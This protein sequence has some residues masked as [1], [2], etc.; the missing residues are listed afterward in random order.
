MKLTIPLTG[1]VLAEG[2]VHGAGDL[3]GDEND[4]IRPIDIDL[5]NVSWIM[6]DVDLENEVMIIEVEPEDTI[7]EP[8]GETDLGTGEPIYRRR[9]TSEQ[10][11]AAFLQH[12]QKLIETHTKGE[13]YQMS[14]CS[15]LNRPL[16]KRV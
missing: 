1:T 2:S 16:R 11:K 14:G 7:G 5:G 3:M 12:A 8:T 15:R 6:V 9:I 10:E 4:P 13:L